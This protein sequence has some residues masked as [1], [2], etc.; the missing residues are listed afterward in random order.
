MYL[1]AELV[2][3]SIDV[4]FNCNDIQA[5]S[6]FGETFSPPLFWFR[7]EMNFV[8][9]INTI[10]LTIFTSVVL[11]KMLETYRNYGITFFNEQILVEGFIIY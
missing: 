4:T 6:H 10:L 2:F 9:A 7:V 1:Q 11:R 3:L 5:H 8:V